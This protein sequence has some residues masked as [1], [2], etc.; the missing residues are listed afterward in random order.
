MMRLF[1][2]ACWRVWLI[3]TAFW[4]MAGSGVTQSLNG[5]LLLGVNGALLR[6]ARGGASSTVVPFTVLACAADADNRFAIV[7]PVGTSVFRVDLANAQVVA[8]VWS[9]APL[10]GAVE[11]FAVDHNGDYIVLDQGGGVPQNAALYRLDRGGATMTTIV[12]LTG[13]NPVG[14]V[15]DKTTGDWL[16][17]DLTGDLVRVDRDTSVVTSVMRVHSGLIE[18]VGQDPHLAD[19]YVIGDGSGSVLRVDVALG[20]VTTISTGIVTSAL[21]IDRAPAS[22]GALLMIGDKGG[23]VHRVRR[24]GIGAAF[25]A[26]VQSRVY[27][28]TIHRSRNLASVLAAPPNQ[29]QLVLDFPAAGGKGYVCAL[30]ASGYTGGL[31]LVDGRVIPLRIDALTTLSARGALA[32]LLTNNIGRLDATGRAVVTFDVNPLGR[33]VGGVRVWAVALTVD[34]AAPASVGEISAPVLFV[35]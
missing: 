1:R 5:D 3:V 33:A 30:S 17:A 26:N 20:T 15:E 23:L 6:V 4:I 9:G 10:T 31:T 18:G 34:P 16:V 28:A 2:L 32:P 27:G 13:R 22:D 7:S 29:R 11:A 35:L 14:L 24:N 25:F 12:T 21:A 8:T 19:V